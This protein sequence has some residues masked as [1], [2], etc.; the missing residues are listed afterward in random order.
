MTSPEP[1]PDQSPAD[2]RPTSTS[3][4]SA[5][6]S[7]GSTSST[8]PWRPG[9]PPAARSGRR[10]GG[11]VVLE[12]LPRRPVRLGELHLRLPVL[13]GALRG[14][15]VAGALRRAARDRAL[16][17]PRGRPLRPPPPHALRRQGHL[18]R[19]RRVVGDMDGD[20]R[21]TAP[22]YRTRFLVAATGVLSVPYFPDVPGR[23]DFAGSRTTRACGRRHRSTSPASGS[24]SSAPARAA[25]R[26]SRS[27]PARSPP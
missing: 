26:S 7:P 14:V 11:D 22:Q 6:A 23:E 4:S 9:S 21:A 16:P 8:A 17:Q 20:R 25:S 10:R 24:R 15:G 19:L 18:C 2:P 13:Q 5:P 12:P 1:A 3:W 27:S